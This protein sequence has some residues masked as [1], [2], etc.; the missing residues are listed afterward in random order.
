MNEILHANIFFVIASVA[1][2]LFS[3]II[4]LV[5][6]HV[7]KIVKSVRRIVEKIEL[8]SDQVADDVAHARSLLYN[9]GMIARVLGFVAGTRKRTR[10]SKSED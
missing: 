8:A 10:R 5:L 4:C 9:G 2:V 1:C 7:L 6:Y 3:I